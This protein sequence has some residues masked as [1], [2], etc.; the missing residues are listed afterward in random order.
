ML[1]APG[2]RVELAV[3]PLPEG[4]LLELEELPYDRGLG[5]SEAVPWATVQVGPTAPT[6][7]AL[8]VARDPLPALADLGAPADRTIVLGGRNSLRHGIE[9]TV[10]DEMFP[11]DR[12]V[13]VGSVQV[14]DVVNGTRLDHPFH[15]HGFFFQVLAVNGQPVPAADRSWEDTVNVPAEATLRIAWRAD[16]RP[17]EW[18]YHCHILEHAESGMMASFA[19]EGGTR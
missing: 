8:P 9:F 7:A 18:M 15:L 16:D 12:P 14:W 3:G 4:A 17:G 1:L 19:V 2:D 13:Q 5:M 6:V 11:R 10:N